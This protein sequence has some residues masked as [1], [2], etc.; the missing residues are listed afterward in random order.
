MLKFNL[1]KALCLL[2]LLSTASFQA[3]AQCGTTGFNEG[4]MTAQCGNFGPTVNVSSTAYRTF[5]VTNGIIYTVSTCGSAWDSQVTIKD[6]SGNN[7]AYNDDNGPD[8]TG[9]TSSVNWQADYTGTAR[10]YVHRY[11]CGSIWPG[12]SA[13]LK[14]R[15]TTTVT[16]TT[17]SATICNSQTKPLTATINNGG[18]P[19]VQWSIFSGPGSISGTNYIPSTAGT[20][21]V[22]AT[23]GLCTSD[24]SFTVTANSGNPATFGSNQWNVYAYIGNNLN[25]SGISYAGFYTESSL[26]FNTTSRWGDASTPSSASGYTGCPVD[27]DYHTVVSKRQGFPAGYYSLGVPA[28]DDDVRLYVNGVQVF[29]HVGCCDAHANVW[30]GYLDGTST[31]EIRHAEGVGGSYHALSFTNTGDPTVFGPNQWNVYGY[32]GG[33]I[34][35]TGTYFGNYTETALSYNS[36][37]RWG[38][39]GSPSDASGW[40]GC[41]VPID[42]HAVASKRQGF[43]CGVYSLTMPNNDDDVQV[44]INGG[45]VASGACCNTLTGSF[46][47][48]YLTSTSTIEV[49]HLEGGGGSNQSLTLTPSGS[50]LNGGTIGGIA[51]PTTICFGQDPGAFT[52]VT[53]PSG[54]TVGIT[55]GSPAAP[56]Y[57]WERAPTNTFASITNVGTNS[58]TFDPDASLAVGTY[59]FRRKVTDACGSVAYSNI[60]QVNV[61]PIHTITAGANRTVCQNAPMTS[62]TMTLG[63]GATGANVTG[64]PTGVTFNVSGLT[65]TIS[66]TPTV[67]GPYNYSVTTTGN[68]CA[69]ASASGTITV[70]PVPTAFSA[71]ILTSTPLCYGSNARIEVPVSQLS[72]GYQLRDNATNVGGAQP[73]T[74]GALTFTSNN[75]TATNGNYNVL[76][77][78]GLGCTTV[79][80]VASISVDAIPSSLGGNGDTR[81]C[82]VNGNNAFVEFRSASGSLIA[83]NPGTENLG[84]VTVTEYAGSPLNSQACGTTQPWYVTAVLGRHWVITPENQPTGS[85]AVRLYYDNSEYTALAAVANA[86]ANPNDDVA[87]QGSLDLSKYSNPGNPSAVNG[88]FTDNCASGGNTTAH[89]PAGTGSMNALSGYGSFPASGLYNL[90]S[91]A[92]F[93]EFWMSGTN[94]VSPLPIVLQ[95][96][97]AS[98]DKGMVRLDWVTATEIN[99][100]QFTIHRSADLMEWEEV[101]SQS[102]AGNSN[103]PLAY[104]GVDERPLNGLSYYRLT[105]RDYDGTTESFEPISVT[106]YTDGSGNSMLVFPNPA[107]DRFTVS[108]TVTEAIN[109]AGIE[110][111][112]MSGKRVML[113]NVNL[114]KG[115]N[116]FTF[117]RSGMN[118]G[119]YFIKLG[120]ETLHITAIKLVVK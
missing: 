73:G 5:P 20:V 72:T 53:S 2:F 54:G 28:H 92:S 36:L 68:S 80:N 21:V 7:K 102:G 120:S 78:T 49:R 4:G 51:D 3:H 42:N 86:N 58:L 65:L 19:T 46:W 8:C 75:L 1:F 93:S 106:C 84:N 110:I 50:A 111:M 64:L 12:T 22:R 39:L 63:G 77:T 27:I 89:V 66:G 98:C 13:L 24:V 56:V 38:S 100:E 115:T 44:Y 30:C 41:Y 55:N 118:P 114:V 82:Y 67:S 88:V 10:A 25:L 70:N 113:R 23:V 61:N 14:V 107:D 71:N 47:T 32:N 83:I 112:D 45:L 16:N 62:I 104:T 85:V 101:L 117:E 59:Y 119:T 103:T 18:S 34:N 9:L 11:D 99:N 95:S 94:N 60:I 26:A 37:S 33:N 40:V 35:L 17:S 52:N 29:E 31:I 15:Q 69:T 81:T 105:Q 108:V 87:A 91:V 97:T 90:Y 79:V 6:D 74:G 76:A 57:Q 96:F 43:P 48:G 116:E 109:N